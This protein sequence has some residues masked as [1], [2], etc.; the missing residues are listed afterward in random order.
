VAAHVP[1]GVAAVALAWPLL[2]LLLLLL[3]VL[4]QCSEHHVLRSCSGAITSH[5]LSQLF[6]KALLSYAMECL[7]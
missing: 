6:S 5:V 4:L 7:L 2:L 3:L 1:K